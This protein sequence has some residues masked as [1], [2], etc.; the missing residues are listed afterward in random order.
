LQPC[1]N[2]AIA[3]RGRKKRRP[4]QVS[5]L[6]DANA[7]VGFSVG[8]YLG[9]DTR[10]TFGTH[11]M[12]GASRERVTTH[13]S[14]FWFVPGAHASE[15]KPIGRGGP[16]GQDVENEP[17]EWV[18]AFLNGEFRIQMCF[19]LLRPGRERA[20]QAGLGVAWVHKLSVRRWIKPYARDAGA[21]GKFADHGTRRAEV[22]ARGSDARC[23][24][25]GFG[26]LFSGF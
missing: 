20:R 7:K 12:R 1:R 26:L 3:R 5:G 10:E 4:A 19:R 15:A 21:G 11:A 14:R 6:R 25:F 8:N 24:T 18:N 16:N 2:G 17:G 9:A 13:A 22:R 23:L